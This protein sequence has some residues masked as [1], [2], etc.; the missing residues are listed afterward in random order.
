ML[1][2]FSENK[3]QRHVEVT[4]ST[5]TI[6]R[7]VAVI[8]GSLL[9]LA[10]IKQ[11]HYALTLILVAFILALA[12]N[13]PVHRLSQHLP[14][15]KRGNRTIAI[16]LSFVAVVFAFTAFFA[17]IIPPLVKQ[18]NNFIDAAP[19]LVEDLRDQNSSLGRF[20]REHKLE[21]EVDKLSDQISDRLGHLSGSLVGTISKITSSIFAVLAIIVLTFMMLLEGPRWIDV[22]RRLV[23][24]VHRDHTAKLAKDMYNVV[25]GY[26]NGQLILA[27]L[28]AIFIFVPLQILHVSYPVALMVLVFIFGL[29]PLVGHTIGAIVVSIIALLHS[30][31]AGAVI[32]VYYVAYQ[33]I[34]N[35]L[36]QPRIQANATNMSPL[37]VFTAV[38][39]GAS[40]NGLIGGLIAIPVAGCLRV[41]V[42]DFIQRR[43]L[44]D[45]AE[46]STTA[47]T[48]DTK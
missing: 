33:Q 12:L 37:L 5:K 20:V 1:G 6:F 16:T 38:L 42:L 29:I 18:T 43:K 9:V 28:A 48:A 39:I 21:D 45:P 31:T 40:L 46:V 17:I 14:G 8:L 22:S 4:V 47:P 19:G 41:L 34:E 27:T 13:E 25:R 26:V 15:K 44:M 36:V 2:W 23:P 30:V 10:A 3:K 7:V 24:R 35:Y 32:F 11:A